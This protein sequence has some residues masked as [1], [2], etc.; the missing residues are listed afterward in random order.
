[1][2]SLTWETVTADAAPDP[3]NTYAA[4]KL[5]QEQLCRTWGREAG[6]TVVALRYHNV[7]GPRMPRD[8]PYAGVVS[9][10]ASALGAGQAPQVFEDGHQMRDFVHVH[11][12]ARANVLALLSDDAEPG[13]YNVA[14]GVPRTVGEVARVLTATVG[15]T[16]PAAEITGR[17]RLGD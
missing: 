3:R 10:F 9:I 8:T 17:W 13:A 15:P 4:T 5:H 1:G 7:Y 12:V 2:H 6:A 16:A 11:D 14:S